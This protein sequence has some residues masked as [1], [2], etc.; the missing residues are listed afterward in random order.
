MLVFISRSV[1]T[2][3][4]DFPAEALNF[5]DSYQRI[6]F[7]PEDRMYILPHNHLSK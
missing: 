2:S 7:K 5:T 6:M 1:M 4:Y 3:E